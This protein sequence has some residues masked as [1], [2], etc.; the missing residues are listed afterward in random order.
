MQCK[1]NLLN[2]L[3]KGVKKFTYVV[4]S[5]SKKSYLLNNQRYHE[6]ILLCAITPIGG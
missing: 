6:Q 2:I 4:S 5:L 3:T 1:P